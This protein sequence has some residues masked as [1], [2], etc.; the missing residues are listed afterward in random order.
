METNDRNDSKMGRP[1]K[2]ED[3]FVEEAQKYFG[4]EPYTK[5]VV[6]VTDSKGNT[7]KKTVYEPTDFPTLA[8]FAISLGVHRDTIYSWAN[9]TYPDDYEDESMRGNLKHPD[10][11]DAIKRAKDYQEHILITNGLRGLYEQPAFIYTT[12]NILG[13]RDKVDIDATTKGEKIGN[14]AAEMLELYRQLMK[15][16][17]GD[18]EPNST[19]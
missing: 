1:T 12:K 2:Y 17:D 7:S 11:S 19:N 9:E 8:G 5:E 3:R 14:T 4:K 6:E 16:E 13:W 18:S 10:F 15:K